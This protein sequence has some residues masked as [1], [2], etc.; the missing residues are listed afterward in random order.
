M[1]SAA[2]KHDND[3]IN[4]PAVNEY[5]IDKWI[6]EYLYYLTCFYISTCSLVNL[7]SSFGRWTQTLLV[8]FNTHLDTITVKAELNLPKRN[9]SRFHSGQVSY[10][11]TNSCFLSVRPPLPVTPVALCVCSDCG[12]FQLWLCLCV[13][14]VFTRWAAG[15]TPPSPA[16]FA[17]RPGD[18]SASSGGGSRRRPRGGEGDGRRRGREVNVEVLRRGEIKRRRNVCWRIKLSEL[19]LWLARSLSQSSQQSVS[20]A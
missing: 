1:Y 10:T 13:F 2:D 8:Y 18:T 6:N 3:T 20:K 4:P 16:V 17:P 11:S 15:T 7:G 19:W 9:M 12:M 5:M 14:S